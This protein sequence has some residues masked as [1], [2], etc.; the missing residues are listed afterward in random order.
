MTQPAA[1]SR[2]DDWDALTDRHRPVLDDGA[3]ASFFRSLPWFRVLSATS[4][5]PGDM[6]QLYVAGDPPALILPLRRPAG[7]NPLRPRRLTSLAN[8]YSCDYA[9]LARAGAPIDHGI[10][11]IA[12]SLRAER[13]RI[14]LVE[15]TSL[16]SAALDAVAHGFAEAGWWVQRYFHFGN[17]FEPTAGLDAAA[18]LARRPAALRNTIKRKAA[19]LR[20]ANDARFDLVLDGHDRPALDRAIEA[21]EQVYRAS[22]KLGEPYPHFAAAFMRACAAA[23]CLRLGLVHIAD[24]P[25]A[26]QIWIVWNGRATLCKLAHDERFKPRSVGSV[27]TWR[28]IEHV[29]SVDQVTEIDFGRGDD[30]YKRLW[31][32]QRREHWGLLACNPSTPRGLLAAARHLGGRPLA[33]ALRRLRDGVT[34]RH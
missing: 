31:M 4:L 19:A 6:L 1:V 26:A 24:R 23:G 11:A 17:W 9:P 20:K 12:A 32:S 7:R 5:D 28:M 27:L 22:W 3:Q 16:P 15:L 2:L 13:P 18:Y 8:F 30:D 21:Y 10:G 34:A 25:A 14:D 33:R 29:L